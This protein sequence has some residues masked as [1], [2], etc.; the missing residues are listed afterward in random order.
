MSDLSNQVIGPYQIEKLLGQGG[1]GAVYRA[2]DIQLQ[3]LVAFKMMHPEIAAHDE[4]RKRFLQEARAIAA[5]DHPNIIRIH[6][7]HGDAKDLYLVME[8]V[9]GGSLRDYLRQLKRDKTHIEIPE[10]IALIKQLASALHFAHKENMVHRDVKPDNVLLKLATSP[11]IGG[12]RFNAVLTDFGLAKLADN[13]IVQTAG[14]NPMGTLPYMPPEQIRGDN[15]DGRTDLYAL[16]ILMYELIVGQLPFAPRNIPEALKMHSSDAP[17]DPSSI[18]EGLAPELEKIILKSIAKH[19]DDRYQTGNEIVDAI[20]YMEAEAHTSVEDDPDE[21]LATFIDPSMLDSKKEASLGTYLAS[22]PGMPDLSELD[23]PATPAGLQSDQIAIM[24]KGY[25]ARYVSIVKQTL[26]IGRDPSSDIEIQGEKVSRNHARIERRADGSYT[27]TDLGSTNGTYMNEAKLLSNV[28]EPWLPDHIVSIGQFRLSIQKAVTYETQ[29]NVEA[30]HSDI[31]GGAIP[32]LAPPPDPRQTQQ[33]PM[34]T[35]GPSRQLVDVQINPSL[36]MVDPGSQASVSV[37]IYNQSDIVEHY[38]IQVQGIPVEWFTVPPNRLQLLP[39][40]RGNLPIAFHPPRNP[41]STAGTHTFSIRVSSE[42]RGAEIGRGTGLITIKPFYQYTVDMEPKRVR[43]R[44]MIRFILNN[45]SNAPDSYTILGRDREEGLNFYPP[46]HS[47][48]V[49]GGLTQVFEFE[50][51]PK[52]GNFIGTAKN[53]PFE[54]QADAAS[55]RQQGQPAELVHPATIPLWMLSILMLLCLACLALLAMLYLNQP[56]DEP[57]V[58]DNSITQTNDDIRELLTATAVQFATR[59]VVRVETATAVA[60]LDDDRDGLTNAEESELGTNPD[61]D[62]SDND[63]LTDGDEVNEYETDPTDSD[64]DDDGLTDGAEIDEYDTDPT[65]EDSD[66]DGLT[67]GAEVFTYNTEPD[68]E[69]SDR[70]TIPDGI[71][72]N[73]TGTDPTLRDTDGDGVHDGLD[74]A[75]TNPNISSTSNNNSE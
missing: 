49:G 44:G 53:Y 20:E 34:T 39:G 9:P 5:L 28:P 4:L 54:V 33:T 11:G 48:S 41:K 68:K 16:G 71:E 2:R 52:R 36:V 72:V 7:F 19:P 58:A 29:R 15:M 69:D 8:Y 63:G 59:E 43:K 13:A 55:G 46:S 10:A 66:E 14:H 57:V 32:G 45:Q 51:R 70:D 17:P 18:R 12:M 75:P 37:E 21:Y 56:E 47:G 40:N 74:P 64:T 23:V 24:R 25:S 35:G 61:N 30:V 73:E 67:D 50:V 38:R 42:E 22:M 3:R 6:S 1:M 31:A 62:D 60:L 27:I 65:E 26:A